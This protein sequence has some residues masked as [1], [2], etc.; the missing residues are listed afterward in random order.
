M[1]MGGRRKSKQKNKEKKG[2]EYFQ[3][4]QK[5]LLGFSTTSYELFGQPNSII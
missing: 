1:G 4:A 3:L 2:K 5:V